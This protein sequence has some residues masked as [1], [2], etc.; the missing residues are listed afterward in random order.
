MR[1][2]GKILDVALLAVD[3]A[4]KRKHSSKH[5]LCLSASHSAPAVRDFENRSSL[6]AMPRPFPVPVLLCA[7][8]ERILQ[9]DAGFIPDP[10]TMDS[11][12]LWA[13]HQFITLHCLSVSS[14]RSSTG[15]FGY[16]EQ[17]RDRTMSP[18]TYLRD[19]FQ[20]NLLRKGRVAYECY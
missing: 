14:Q 9:R 11:T 13:E 15:A 19:S 4:P 2:V 8:P 18:L 12:P 17:S 20:D 10:T 16:L 1:D 5:L 7:E 6:A 3:A